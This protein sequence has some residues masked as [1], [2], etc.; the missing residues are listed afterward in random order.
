MC[1]TFYLKDLTQNMSCIC[2]SVVY[3]YSRGGWVAGY[4]YVCGSVVGMADT[5]N[6]SSVMLTFIRF[7]TKTACQN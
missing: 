4:M 1:Q 3:V 6:P 7:P 2:A 5:N